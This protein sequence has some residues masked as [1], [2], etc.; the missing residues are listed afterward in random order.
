MPSPNEYVS[1]SDMHDH[2]IKARF[3][4]RTYEMLKSIS[5]HEDIPVAVLVRRFVVQG[6][7]LEAKNNI[8]SSQQR[9]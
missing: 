1:T 9:G 7:E 5:L 6:I 8:T 4:G 3:K 2:E